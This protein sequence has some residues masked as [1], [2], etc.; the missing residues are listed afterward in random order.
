MIRSFL[1]GQRGGVGILSS[2]GFMLFSIPLITGS[3]GLASSINIDARVKNGIL[4][5]DYCGLALEQHLSYLAKDSIRWETWL[6]D[7]EDPGNP[8]TSIGTVVI[9][10][11][12]I[13]IT[14]IQDPDPPEGDDDDS[15]GT[16]PITGA[17]NQRDFQTSK[18]VSD[19]NP[20]GGSPVTYTIKVQNRG[21][22]D[23]GLNEI[24]DTLPPGFSY[25][26]SAPPDRLTLPGMDPQDIVPDVG[27]CPTGNEVDWSMPPGTVLEPGNEVTLTFTAVTSL[28]TGAYCNELQVVPGG[29]KTRSGKTAVVEIGTPAAQPLCSGE[30]V[31]VSQT[32]DSAVLVF[33]DLTTTPFTYTFDVDYTIT[34]NNIGTLDLIIA[35]FVDLLPV[36]FSYLST[37]PL[38]DITDAPNQLHYVSSIDRQRVTWDFSPE[39]LVPSG[40][41][42][43]LKF[44]TVAVIG[45]G[46]YWVDLLVDFSGGTFSEDRYSWPSAVVS[47]VDVY[48]VIVT[49]SDGNV[50]G[51]VGL[52]VWMAGDGGVIASWNLP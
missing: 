14:V 13:T 21:E 3:L 4:Q 51:V 6:V 39:I 24:R 20:I 46:D 35:G 28:D 30:A 11:E 34:V 33:T 45:Q 7:N 52:Q 42:T 27:P 29:T 49:D 47:V 15:E 50:I 5:Q 8:G 1:N 38:G 44:S 18:T 10:G 36:G 22:D 19:P 32:M 40:T 12:T 9:C 41:A 37:S 26:C 43:T 16:I 25:D 17:Y 31:T 2:L 23:I 48:D